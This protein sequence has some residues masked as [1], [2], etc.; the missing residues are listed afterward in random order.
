MITQPNSPRKIT[1]KVEQPWQEPNG[2]SVLTDFEAKE[3]RDLYYYFYECRR[4]FTIHE[5]F[6]LMYEDIVDQ[7]VLS[8]ITQAAIDETILKG[9]LTFWILLKVLPHHLTVR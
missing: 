5:L 8:R 1:P 3:L 9:K 4:V 6:V 2:F 7:P